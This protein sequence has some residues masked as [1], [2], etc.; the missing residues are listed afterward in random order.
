M[1]KHMVKIGQTAGFVASMMMLLLLMGNN[2]AA[3]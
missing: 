1:N 3:G 2:K